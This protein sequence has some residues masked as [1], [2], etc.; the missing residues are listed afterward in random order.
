[1]IMIG[2]GAAALFFG[3]TTYQMQRQ[4]DEQRQLINAGGQKDEMSDKIN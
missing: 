1:M 3:M 4:L 2:L